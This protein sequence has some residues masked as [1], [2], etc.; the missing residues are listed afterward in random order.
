MKKKTATTKGKKRRKGRK[1]SRREPRDGNTMNA[2][3]W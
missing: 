3:N 2:S 1:E